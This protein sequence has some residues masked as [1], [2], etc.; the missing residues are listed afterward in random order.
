M[1][2]GSVCPRWCSTCI[3]MHPAV[4]PWGGQQICM[5]SCSFFTPKALNSSQLRAVLFPLPLLIHLRH[6]FERLV[7]QTGQEPA[8]CKCRVYQEFLETPFNIKANK[9][10]MP[11]TK[12]NQQSKPAALF[13]LRPTVTSIYIGCSYLVFQ[14]KQIAIM[15]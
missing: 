5:F 1:I 14:Q 7:Q 6:V 4:L 11:H 2:K 12:N 15:Q 10:L 3:P 8:F 13:L 9:N